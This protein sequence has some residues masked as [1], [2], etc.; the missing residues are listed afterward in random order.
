MSVYVL[1]GEIL[2]ADLCVTLLL[3]AALFFLC[4]PPLT[5]LIVV[6]NDNYC[7][8]GDVAC[9]PGLQWMSILHKHVDAQVDVCL[10]AGMCCLEGCEW[11]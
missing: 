1:H 3:C 2:L 11:W 5:C 8:N 9:V 4:T 7:G 6:C 10:N